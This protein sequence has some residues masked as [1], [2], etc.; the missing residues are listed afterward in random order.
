ML[1]ILLIYVDDIL[2]IGNNANYVARFVGELGKLFSTNDLGPLHF[3]L[4]IEATYT[5]GG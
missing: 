5:D 1:I 2:I 3:F 4:G